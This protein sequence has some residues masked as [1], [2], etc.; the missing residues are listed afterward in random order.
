MESINDPVVVTNKRNISE[1]CN[2]NDVVEI[3]TQRIRLEPLIETI[4]ANENVE[5]VDADEANE[6]ETVDTE[7]IAFKTIQ[8]LYDYFNDE[9]RDDFSS[10]LIKPEYFVESDHEFLLSIWNRE[11][12]DEIINNSDNITT[13]PKMLLCIGEYV[14]VYD[15]GMEETHLDNELSLQY[16]DKAAA[17]VYL[18]QHY[19]DNS[20]EEENGNEDDEAGKILCKKYYLKAVKLNHVQSMFKLGGIY[21]IEEDYDMMKR[22]YIQACEAMDRLGQYYYD[23]EK[24]ATLMIRYLD[25]AIEIEMKTDD[26][27]VSNS[28]FIY[29]AKY[30]CNEKNYDL[31]KKYYLL[32]IEKGCA[33][34]MK[35]LGVY[36]R[37]FEKNYDLALSYLNQAQ[38]KVPRGDENVYAFASDFVW[39]DLALTY[40]F[41]KDYDNM[42]VYFE[43]DIEGP[44]VMHV[45]KRTNIQSLVA[46]GCYYRDIEKNYELMKKHFI[47][48]SNIKGRSSSNSK[49][50]KTTAMYYLSNYYDTIER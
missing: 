42:K 33:V 34:G 37:D 26:N 48:A 8:E 18:A 35:N 43:K 13:N 19:F 11:I 50:W 39:Y 41:M 28:P 5:T 38:A 15:V 32:L 23:V 3:E 10:D 24:N 30:H 2:D 9:D 16:F 4:E 14:L 7:E 29:L 27:P 25:Q 1:V 17:I 44:T 36:Y 31:M 20:W 12:D 40:R 22:Y 49:K 47:A 46:F 45:Y 21:Q 6:D